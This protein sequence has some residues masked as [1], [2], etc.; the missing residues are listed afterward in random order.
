MHRR[1]SIIQS[2]IDLPFIRGFE[3]NLILD[4]L[5]ENSV[6]FTSQDWSEEETDVVHLTEEDFTT[7]LRKKK[8]VLVMFYAPW[9]GHCKSAKVRVIPSMRDEE[10]EDEGGGDWN[11]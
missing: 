2:S 1:W 10:D 5:V 7:F 11:W 4:R 6:V 9:C 8:H 3:R